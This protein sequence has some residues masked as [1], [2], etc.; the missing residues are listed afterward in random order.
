MYECERIFG[1]SGGLEVR[2]LIEKA[3]GRPCPCTEGRACPLMPPV[4]VA[5][6]AV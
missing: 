5:A 3:T 2:D 4:A 1:I 6:A